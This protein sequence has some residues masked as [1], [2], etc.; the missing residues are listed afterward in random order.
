[1]K[2][3]NQKDMALLRSNTR[4]IK[5]TTRNISENAAEI[6]NGI[7]DIGSRALSVEEIDILLDSMKD[8]LKMVTRLSESIRANLERNHTH[9]DGI[10]QPRCRAVRR[11]ASQQVNCYK[12][13]GHDESTHEGR[14]E[15][16]AG[17]FDLSWTDECPD[18]IARDI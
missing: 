14:I 2:A 8:D 9:N 12:V 3:F 18:S 11:Y 16:I 17:E 5:L 10:L 13:R 1:M 15:N 7:S 4:R 6:L